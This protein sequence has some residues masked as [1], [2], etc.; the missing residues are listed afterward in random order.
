MPADT[1]FEFLWIMLQYSIQAL[2]NIK[3][4]A[5]GQKIRNN[6]ELL[7]AVVTISLVLDVTGFLDLTLKHIEKFRL[8]Q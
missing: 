7:L 2:S 3:D 1:F 4:R 8:R 5:L 6:W